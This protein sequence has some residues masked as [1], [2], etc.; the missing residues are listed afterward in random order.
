MKGIEWAVLALVALAALLIGG[1]VFSTNTVSEKVVTQD[2]VVYVNVPTAD[3]TTNAKLDQLLKEDNFEKVALNLAISK[4]D[5]DDVF[6]AL[7]AGGV[8]IWDV[9]DIKS[10]VVDDSE[11]SNVDADEKDA[12]VTL[13]LIVRYEDSDGD[14]VKVKVDV[15]AEVI[16]G[17]LKDSNIDYVLD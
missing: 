12:D 4:L 17:K 10:V 13:N 7:E 3:N 1:F 16:D 15:T 11:V 8:S 6:D 2:K 5:N 14:N 9:E